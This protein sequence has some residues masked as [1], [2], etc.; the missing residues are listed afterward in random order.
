M[1]RQ[2]TNRVRA[3][4]AV[5]AMRP[6]PIT[7]TGCYFIAGFALVGLALMQ[8][9]PVRPVSGWFIG[10][11]GAGAVVVAVRTEHL[12]LWEKVGWIMVAFFF[13]ALEMNVLYKDRA[14]HEHE[15]SQARAQQL[16]SFNEI[17]EGIDKTIQNS[18]R[19]FAATMAR[20]DSLLANITGGSSFA[21]VYPLINPGRKDL[22]LYI[23][24]R[25]DNI[26]TGVSVEINTQ[27]VFWPGAQ[28]VL[29]RNASGRINV[30][31]LHAHETLL[32]NT[33]IKSEELSVR[34]GEIARLYLWINQ[35]NFTAQ[36]FLELRKGT[37]KD[38]PWAFKYTIYRV[39]RPKQISKTKRVSG[40]EVKL[41]ES[42]WSDV[43]DMPAKKP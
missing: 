38:K 7:R 36:E 29:M 2:L 31:T 19:E 18:D 34:E 22:P 43:E 13:C 8:D 3:K 28:D 37:T 12:T 39:G 20:T 11:L 32:L 26:L 23:E 9:F 5:I 25:G 17:A 41:G 14:E 16:K 27:A 24:N 40:T 6:V 35:Q 4:V 33:L 42:G 10:I 15:Q 21:V 30:G 1:F